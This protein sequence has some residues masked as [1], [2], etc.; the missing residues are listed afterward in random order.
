MSYYEA[1]VTIRLCD[2]IQDVQRGSVRLPDEQTESSWS[3]QQCFDLIDSIYRGWPIGTIIIWETPVTL[4][5]SNYW[6]RAVLDGCQ[7][8]RSLMNMLG[9][10]LRDP[11]ANWK[12]RDREWV[13][14]L[15]NSKVSRLP[16]DQISTGIQ[17]PLSVVVNRATLN[18]WIRH[19]DL[20][21]APIR[22]ADTLYDRLRFSI[23]I[24]KVPISTI[25]EAQ[26]L[27]QRVNTIGDHK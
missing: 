9:D 23:Q 20:D 7:R 8:I 11:D 5:D 21:E 10:G 14:D 4:K 15:S 22:K 18:R 12:L 17:I 3:E 1:P 19:Y 27:R 24:C 25:E 26:L 13:F 2:L 16:V 6:P